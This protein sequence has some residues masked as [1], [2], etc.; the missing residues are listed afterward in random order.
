MRYF[1][2]EHY[3]KS[4]NTVGTAGRRLLL[5]ARNAGRALG[6]TA[7]ACRWLGHL[8]RR[9]REIV[10]QMYVCGIKS[11]GVTSVVALF[12]GMVLALQ[13]GLVL[14]D[15][16]QQVQVGTLVSQTLCREM[17]PFMTAL[18]LAASVGSA[19]AAELG[20]MQVSEEIA[21]MHVMSVNP[22]SYLVMPR[23]VAFVIMCPVLTIYTNIV[24]I[25]G[26]MLV[27]R[28][29]LD[30][31][32]VAYYSNALQYL[33]NKEVYVGLFKAVVFSVVIVTVACYQGFT[34]RNG[35]AGVGRATRV[36]VVH[37]FLLVLVTGY[38]ITRMF[39]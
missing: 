3:E 25:V 24:G 6:I 31:S 1:Q 14:Q 30:V 29:Q 12:T 9:R 37:S 2:P 19:M 10:R 35:A 4:P 26:G 11:F 13:A 16:G 23:L 33:Q 28:T 38:V 8:P 34:A 7:E 39:Y 5:L 32:T 15:Y 27:A 22:A 21:A 18:I 20:T 17:G 36:T